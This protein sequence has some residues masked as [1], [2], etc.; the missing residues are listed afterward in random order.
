LQVGCGKW[1]RKQL[2]IVSSAIVARSTEALEDGMRRHEAVLVAQ[3]VG[4]E[5]RPS[6]V[7]WRC[8]HA[9]SDGI[10]LDVAHARQKMSLILDETRLVAAFEARPGTSVTIVD[11]LYENESHSNASPSRG[12]HAYSA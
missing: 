6:I 10:F 4:T 1:L 12:S 11:L 3:G 9:G 5:A 8:D 7:S 2:A